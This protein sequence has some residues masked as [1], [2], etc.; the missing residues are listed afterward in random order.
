MG[1]VKFVSKKVKF[2][3]FLTQTGQKNY[4]H[5]ASVEGAPSIIAKTSAFPSFRYRFW[6]SGFKKSE[7]EIFIPNISS[8]KNWAAEKLEHDRSWTRQSFY[9]KIG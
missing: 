6:K 7:N 8:K 1:N 3:H 5:A 4:L 9:T 2:F